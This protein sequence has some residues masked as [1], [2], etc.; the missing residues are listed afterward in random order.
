MGIDLVR[1]LTITNRGNRYIA[2]VMDYLTKWPK[3][4]AIQRV[5]AESQDII[6]ATLFEL[7]YG[8][9]ATL[10][11]E[12]EVSTYLTKPITKNNFQK[13]LL[14]KTND[15]I[16]TLKNKWQRAANNIQKLQK[17]QWNRKFDSK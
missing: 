17:K 10:P 14:K 6:Q 1:S 2:V 15:L 5:D 7:V 9:T 16:E 12:I 8:S 4:K 3:A 11:M 13:T